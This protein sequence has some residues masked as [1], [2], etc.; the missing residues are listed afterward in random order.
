MHQSDRSSKAYSGGNSWLK[1]SDGTDS[2]GDES[3]AYFGEA[4]VVVGNNEMTELVMDS[5]GSYHMTYM[6]DFLYDYNEFDGG[7]VQ[8]SDNRTCTTKGTGKVKIQLHDG[9]SF[10]L[11]GVIWL[12]DKQLEEKTNTDCLV[13]EQEKVHLGIKVETNI[14]V[15][16]VPGQEGVEGNVAENMNVKE[17]MEANLEK[18]LKY[19]GQQCGLRFERLIR[20]EWEYSV[21]TSV[22]VRALQTYSNDIHYNNQYFPWRRFA[23]FPSDVSLG[24][25]FPSEMSLGNLHWGSLVRDSFPSDNPQRRGGPHTFLVKELVP[26]WHIFP[27]R[28]VAG[29]S[30]GKLKCL[31]PLIK[32]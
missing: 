19:N 22:L 15:T 8:L 14:M 11:K 23:T 10:I 27:Q 21:G 31:S 4:L 1:L 12:E 25:A 9:S 13:K 29:E 2:L 30:L 3:N 16:G 20:R 7:S 17:S 32:P 28:H 24:K 26:R 6:R 18:L 5:G